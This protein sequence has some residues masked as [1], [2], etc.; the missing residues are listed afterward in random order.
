MDALAMITARGGSQRIPGKNIKPF[1]GKPIIA[2]SIA[3]ALES[4]IFSEIMVSTD[5][6]KIEEISLKYGARVPFLRSE[7]NSDN[8]APLSEVVLEVLE[9][10]QK[11]GKSFDFICLILPTAPLIKKENLI[12]AYSQIVREDDIDCVFT[13]TE[14]SFPIQR[15]LKIESN[16]LKMNW[17]E[18]MSV[19]SQDLESTYHDAGQFY[20]LRTGTFLKQ[21]KIYMRNSA[22]VILN[23]LEVQD[24]DTE[25]D[26]KLAE[27]KYKLIKKI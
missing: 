27:L 26:W 12:R 23:N 2:Y 9:E 6:K 22:P 1:L 3:A 25:N 11:I 10:Y 7:K 8:H 17:P 16:F 15:S 4:K 21:K 20:F 14:Y 18:N 19:R 5:D 13:V 24:I